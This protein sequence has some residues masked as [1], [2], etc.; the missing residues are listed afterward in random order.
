MSMDF[1]ARGVLLCQN[2]CMSCEGRTQKRVVQIS[3]QCSLDQPM[4]LKCQCVRLQEDFSCFGPFSAYRHQP[5]NSRLLQGPPFRTG[6]FLECPTP[7]PDCTL[8]VTTSPHSQCAM[9]GEGIVKA[10][11]VS[12]ANFDEVWLP[13]EIGPPVQLYRRQPKQCHLHVKCASNVPLLK[14]EPIS[15]TAVQE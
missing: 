1:A 8:T 6:V 4:N 2:C 14:S 11:Y 3:E 13:L 5:A 9:P 10:F 15:L 7:R 12:F